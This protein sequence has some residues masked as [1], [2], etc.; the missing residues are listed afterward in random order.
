MKIKG[1]PIVKPIEVIV[2]E[3]VPV[4]VTEDVALI[5]PVGTPERL[6]VR[7]FE[8]SLFT[9][10][11]PSILVEIVHQGTDVI[12]R[13]DTDKVEESVWVVVTTDEHQIITEVENG[14]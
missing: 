12:L 11:I 1:T 14:G 4:P 3:P 6:Q 5:I 10:E 7:V 8:D 9:K 2:G 13:L